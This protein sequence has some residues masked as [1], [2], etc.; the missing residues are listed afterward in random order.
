M[1]KRWRVW[2]GVL[3]SCGL[4]A[5]GCGGSAG[6][7]DTGGSAGGSGGSTP[8]TESLKTLSAIPDLNLDSLDAAL[9][10]TATSL[11]KN[12]KA[13]ENSSTEFSRAG[14]ELRS[15][16]DEMK[17][18]LLS[19]RV[20]KCAM[21]ALEAN[22]SAAV[23]VN[24]YNYYQVTMPAETDHELEEEETVLLKVG[25][26]AEGDETLRLFLCEPNPAGV[27]E[28]TLTS[29]YTVVDEK[30][31]GTI[32]D[33]LPSDENSG[34]SDASRIEV[35]LGTEA[36]ADWSDGDTAE[37]SGQYNGYYGAG[38]IRLSVAKTSDVL[39]NTV[40]AAFQSGDADTAWGSWTS[41]VSG[42]Y[43][44][45]EGCSLWASAGTYP[46]ETVGGVF[47][48]V[49]QAELAAVGL[50][51][52]DPF[53]WKEADDP[54]N[55]TLA[56]WTEAADADGMCAYNEGGADNLECFSYSLVGT[57][58]NYYTLDNTLAT[59]ADDV[60]AS[61]LDEFSA[62]TVAFTSSEAWDCS[63][64]NGFTTIDLTDNA[65]AVEDL[66]SCFAL[67][68]IENAERDVNSCEDLEREEDAEENLDEEF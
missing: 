43:D 68:E 66:A 35:E 38:N 40:N 52:N 34:E 25:Y 65:A 51:P 44:V 57:T 33:I 3:T 20:E 1:C 16:V 14:C 55:S 26:N 15:C 56:D 8:T 48:A 53:C 28:H 42:K 62:P 59:Y 5:A 37:I 41:R 9:Q 2:I 30:F 11:S 32:V 29:I 45:D 60:L 64:P 36:V 39:T 50:G 46:A 21:E 18:S 7:G 17:S 47:N 54:D 63:A 19:F 27:T 24:Q 13:T 49:E 58:L 6:S 4:L 67:E 22:T 12:L 31:R 61:S 23:G 10:S